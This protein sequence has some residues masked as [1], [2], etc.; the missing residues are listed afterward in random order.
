MRYYLSTK[1][2]ITHMKAFSL[3][4]SVFVLLSMSACS[5]PNKGAQDRLEL[6]RTLFFEKNFEQ[7]KLEIDSIK[8]L[9][10]KSYEQIKGGMALQDSV[11]MGENTYLIGRCDSMIAV[12]QPSIDSM[13]IFFIY[14]R[15]EQYQE[16]G[17]G[18]FIPKEAYG[19]KVITTTALRSGV[20]ENGELYIESVF[21][22]GQMHDRLKIAAKDGA[23]AETLPV[24][25]DGF[26]FRFTNLGQQYEVIRFTGKKENGVGAF[27]SDNQDKQLT[28]TLSGGGVNSYILTPDTKKSITR[29]V[30]LSRM[31]LVQ[32]S[33]K[34]EKEKA[35]YKNYYLNEKKAK[36]DTIATV[37]DEVVASE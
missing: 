36:S 22:G 12:I 27:V 29:S 24:I 15:D 25:E 11:R 2:F 21:L 26:N 3:Y 14:E 13:K 6:A 23:S 10:P 1:I 18:S 4:L 19:G 37:V 5:D 35:E 20:S 7:A 34:G 17:H 16:E 9:F 32:D 8:I 33:L 28:V 31:M 30:K